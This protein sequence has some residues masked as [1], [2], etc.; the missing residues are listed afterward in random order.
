MT[1]DQDRW[2][3]EWDTTQTNGGE[4]RIYLRLTDKAGNTFT[5]SVNVLVSNALPQAAVTES[6]T[7]DQ[8]GIVSITPG[9]L[10]IR[11]VCLT[12]QDPADE[13]RKIEW[14]GE[15]VESIPNPVRWDGKFADGTIA[16]P[17]QYRVTVIVT[18]TANR[19]VSASGTVIVPAPTATPTI[20]P[21][22][23]ES[24]GNTPTRLPLLPTATPTPT[25][26]P[27]ETPV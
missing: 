3:Y 4:K 14:C 10:P 5:T 7:I 23:P 22:I 2:S 13:T 12:I 15:S 16:G 9:D 24:G 19:T 27:T 8:S 21:V 20:P 18:D 26:T 6:W 25:P 11:Q 1:A 17:G